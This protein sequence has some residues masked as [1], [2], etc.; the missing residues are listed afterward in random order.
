MPVT[1]LVKATHRGTRRSNE[2]LVLR[3][4]YE[5]GP[6]S[7]ADV[8]RATELTRTTVSDLV[9]GLLYAGLVVEAGTG[10]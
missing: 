1:T 9:E 7:R 5:D 10:P 8:A 3:T 6:L 4:I 2:R